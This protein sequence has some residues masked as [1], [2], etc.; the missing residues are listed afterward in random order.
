M[1]EWWE[2]VKGDKIAQGDLVPTCIVPIMPSEIDPSAGD[3]VLT[4]RFKGRP[5]DL[6]VVT[7]TCDIVDG[8]AT[9]VAC[10][11]FYSQPAFEEKN[12]TFGQGGNW[13]NVRKGGVK[14]LHLLLSPLNPTNPQAALVVEFRQLFSLPLD[15]LK[16]RAA[17]FSVR[18][19]L[20]SPY[21]E[22]FS[23]AFGAY[24]MRVALPHEIPKFPKAPKGEPPAAS[25]PR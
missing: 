6:I 22:H 11:P 2:D 20:K 10:C 9:L 7:Q 25:T 19:R 12:P 4:Y 13:G 21:L 15:Y 18:Y 8:A 3:D 5:A 1:N 16:T 17:S 23:Q 14:G 24:F